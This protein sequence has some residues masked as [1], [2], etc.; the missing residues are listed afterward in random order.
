MAL[1][2]PLTDEQ[3]C[4]ATRLVSAP[5]CQFTQPNNDTIRTVIIYGRSPD[6]SRG[7]EHARSLLR[8]RWPHFVKSCLL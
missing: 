5:G 6:L 4:N 1:H 3:A 7:R 8:K 2:S